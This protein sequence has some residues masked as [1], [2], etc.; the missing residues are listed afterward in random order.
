MRELAP[1]LLRAAISTAAN[2][3][4]MISLLQPKYSRK[5]TLFTMSCILAADFGSALWCYLSGNLTLLARLDTVLFA[6]LCFAVRPL[7]KDT[8]MQWMFNYLT[9]QNISDIVIIL[10]FLGSRKMPCPPYANSLLRFL[11]FGAFI[12]FLVRFIRPLYRQA[13]EHWTAYFAVALSV[14][15]AFTWYTLTADDVVAML[16]EQAVPL[17]LIIFMALCAYGSIFLSLKNLQREFRLKEENREMQDD[18]VLLK[19]SVKS[20]E[21]RL[22]IMNDAAAAANRTAHDRRHFDNTLLE[23]LDRNRISDAENLL[24]KQTGTHTPAIEN[25]CENTVVNAAVSFYVHQAELAGIRTQIHLEIPESLH[26]DPLELSMA[27]SNLLENAIHG[28]GSLQEDQDKYLYF[29]CRNMGR[30]LIEMENPCR[31]DLLPGSDGFPV[32]ASGEHGTGTKSVE[33]FVKKYDGELLYH[34][35]NGVFQVR[36]LI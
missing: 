19:M 12:L 13:V 3:F 11:L 7:F 32:T 29:T 10:S 33:S 36:I 6:V 34:I 31:P 15:T 26:M 21:E 25:Y 14:Y 4:L 28:C 27:V 18:A 23:L 9:V 24:R 22:Q 20:M 16:T 8:F 1:E 2:V 30:L 17:L 5:V 35:E